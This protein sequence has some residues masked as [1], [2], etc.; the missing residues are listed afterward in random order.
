MHA[1]TTY[2]RWIS[3]I[4]IIARVVTLQALYY[5]CTRAY[6]S[7][8]VRSKNNF[9]LTASLSSIHIYETD[10][11]DCMLLEVTQQRI[12]S[13]YSSNCFHPTAVRQPQHCLKLKAVITAHSDFD[14]WP[15]LS[16]N[17]VANNMLARNLRDL[18]PATLIKQFYIELQ[19]KPRNSGITHLTELPCPHPKTSCHCASNDIPTTSIANFLWI[20]SSKTSRGFILYS[21]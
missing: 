2:N 16:C 5:I 6:E 3:S 15:K 8:Y 1:R 11:L 17:L 20:C 18:G 10:L 7:V 13:V 14:V 19:P 12:C 21:S 9:P 4:W